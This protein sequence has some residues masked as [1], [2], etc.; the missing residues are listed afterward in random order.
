[1]ARQT[2]CQMLN[3]AIRDEVAANRMY[4]QMANRTSNRT[5]RAIIR[6]IARDERHH[7]RTF[8]AIRALRCRR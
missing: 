6:S 4:R 7:A 3:A 2:F 1:M 8:R 5:I